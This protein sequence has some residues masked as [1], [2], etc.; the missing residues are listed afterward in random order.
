M[1]SVVRYLG[2]PVIDATGIQRAECR[3]E[4]DVGLGGDRRR[5]RVHGRVVLDGQEVRT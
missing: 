5:H 4:V 3:D 2:A 1:I